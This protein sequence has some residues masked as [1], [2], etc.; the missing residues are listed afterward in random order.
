MPTGKEFFKGI[1]RENPI[2]R[3]I[4]GLCPALAISTSVNNVLGMSA[5]VLFVMVWSNMIISLIRQFTLPMIRIPIFILIIAFFVTIV[6]LVMAGFFPA[7][8][9]SLGLYIPL[10][11]VNCI[12]L[13]RAEAFASKNGVWLSIVDGFGMGIG[14]SLVLL[15]IATIREILGNGTW[16]GHPVLGS[17]FEPTRLMIQPS[18]AFFTIALLLS[19]VNWIEQRKKVRKPNLPSEF[20]P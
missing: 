6:E 3:M 13:G 11:V 12:I 18:G 9:K 4:L 16:M 19:F 1:C 2:L 14:Y 15:I 7:L 8:H 5:A 10:I 17:R 20:Q